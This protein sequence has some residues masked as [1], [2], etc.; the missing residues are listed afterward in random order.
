LEEKR[1]T[2]SVKV[3]PGIDSGEHLFLRGQGDDGQSGGPPGDLFVNI[4]VKPHPYLTRRGRD[5]EY[6]TSINFAQAA[7]GTELIVPTLTGKNVVKVPA[8]TQGGTSL[9]LRGEGMVSSLG[10]G[11]MFVHIDISIPEKLTPRMQDL[12]EKIS[13]EF[14]AYARAR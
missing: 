4:R 2:L 1:V 11:D 10:K 14:E 6:E 9:R 13:E 12:V 3:P 8:G 5:L 7:L